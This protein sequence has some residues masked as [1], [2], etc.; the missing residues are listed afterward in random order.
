MKFRNALEEAARRAGFSLE[1]VW[2]EA[3]AL[4]CDDWAALRS[5]IARDR[6]QRMVADYVA[7]GLGEF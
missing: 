2:H 3:R 1:D 4:G 7:E 6:E 5:L